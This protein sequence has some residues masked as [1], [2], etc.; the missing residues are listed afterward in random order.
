M[1]FYE[2]VGF[3]EDQV[4]SGSFGIFNKFSQFFSAYKNRARALPQAGYS[5]PI[6]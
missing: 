3:K 4:F 5:T 2:V 1:R 6:E